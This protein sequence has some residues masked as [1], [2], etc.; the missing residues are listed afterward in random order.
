VLVHGAGS[1]RWSFD[2]VRP[3]LEARSTVIRDAGDRAVLVGHSYGG[4]VAAGA[5]PLLD[6]PRLALY[7]PVMG[8]GLATRETVDRWERLIAEDE[9]D[10]P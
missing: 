1:A 5:A 4:L 10:T 2:A 8:G 6:L 9:R 3:H 7:E